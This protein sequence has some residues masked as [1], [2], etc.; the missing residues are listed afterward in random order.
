MRALVTSPALCA[1]PCVPGVC[2]VS[3][4]A[5]FIMWQLVPGLYNIG[6]TFGFVAQFCARLDFAVDD[7]EGGKGLT[8]SEVRVLI[9]T[10][11]KLTCLAPAAQEACHTFI[12]T[13]LICL[14]IG[15]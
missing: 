6:L 9:R 1:V 8:V 3:A 7:A 12:L 14:M 5:L 2:I 10:A 4:L 13:V 11:A 15:E